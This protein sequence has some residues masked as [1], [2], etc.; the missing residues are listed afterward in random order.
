MKRYFILF[1]IVVGCV[2]VASADDSRRIELPAISQSPKVEKLNNGC[3][4]SVSTQKRSNS[5]ETDITVEIENQ[6]DDVH[7]FLFRRAFRVKELRKC[8]PAICFDKN[9]SSGNRELK[10]CSALED[11]RL[12]IEPSRNKIIHCKARVGET[13]R[14]TLPF[15]IAKH[16]ARR[17][18]SKEKYM[19]WELDNV[20]LDITITDNRK[21]GDE[22]VSLS[23]Q[24]DELI[25]DLQ[26]KPFCKN[27]KHSPT[28]AEQMKTFQNRIDDLKDQISDI[29]QRSNWR[30]RSAEYTPYKE[31]LEKLNAINLQT[32]VKD[33]GEHHRPERRLHVCDY[34]K[35]EPDDILRDIGKIYK[36][37]DNGK[38]KKAS[39]TES[40]NKLKK[41]WEGGCPVLKKKMTDSA[42]MSKIKAYYDS[43]VN[44]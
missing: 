36:N 16:K 25:K 29:K 43:I 41:V 33:C 7:I 18:L 13:P 22:I 30:E 2:V 26:P 3:T 10:T 27:P 44:Y 23:E 8:K 4:I 38:I 12:H 11:D 28:L 14:L 5:D 9:I 21:S 17:F 20:E 31:L 6:N 19:L 35:Y 1:S 40:A 37:L 32:F 39:A 15:Y 34:D 24:Y 42:I